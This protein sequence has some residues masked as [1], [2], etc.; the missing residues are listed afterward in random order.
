MV[1]VNTCFYYVFELT[2]LPRT[3]ICTTQNSKTNQGPR[4]RNL[5]HI[6]HMRHIMSSTLITGGNAQGEMRALRRPLYAANREYFMESAGVPYLHTSCFC[7]RNLIRSTLHMVL[8][9]L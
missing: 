1:T 3:G 5:I 8:C 4:V 7:I 2:E 6:M 9:L